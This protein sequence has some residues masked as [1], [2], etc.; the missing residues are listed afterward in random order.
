MLHNS[1]DTGYLKFLKQVVGHSK[2]PFYKAL[3]IKFSLNAWTW[4]Q[5]HHITKTMTH[6][7]AT[8]SDNDNR[9]QNTRTIIEFIKIYR[10]KKYHLPKPTHLSL[11]ILCFLSM[12]F[13]CFL[14][15]DINNNILPRDGWYE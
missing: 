5:L 7:L 10:N 13:P 4:M 2:T 3:F 8:E 11:P 9:V 1:N 15:A 6:F 14:H 12:M